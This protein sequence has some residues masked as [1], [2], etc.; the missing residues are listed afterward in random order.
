T[1]SRRQPGKFLGARNEF[2]RPLAN[3]RTVLSNVLVKRHQRRT[4]AATVKEDLRQLQSFPKIFDTRGN[5]DRQVVPKIQS[6][7]VVRT[8]IHAENIKSSIHQF[9]AGYVGEPIS[10]STH[11]SRANRSRR[12]R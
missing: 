12:I 3:R 6:L 10:I 8:A 11:A 4:A 5:V 1:V 7:V 9:R 2:V